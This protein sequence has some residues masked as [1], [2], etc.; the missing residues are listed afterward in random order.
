MDTEIRKYLENNIEKNTYTKE[1]TNIKNSLLYLS[2]NLDKEQLFFKVISIIQKNIFTILN[3]YG[4]DFKV[5]FIKLVINFIKNN[6]SNKN[7]K[8]NILS[9]L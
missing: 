2:K 7:F 8:S 5:I 3:T 1:Y 4:N 6:I 9:Y